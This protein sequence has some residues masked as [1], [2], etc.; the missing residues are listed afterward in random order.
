MAACNWVISVLTPLRSSCG[1][2]SARRRCSARHSFA[3]SG[4]A[5]VIRP[6]Q[7]MLTH[8]ASSRF[9]YIDQNLEFSD[10]IARVR[11]WFDRVRQQP[12]HVTM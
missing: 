5:G 7:V 1:I 8:T 4:R 6:E 9:A 10:R 11:A 3:R 2:D 12:G